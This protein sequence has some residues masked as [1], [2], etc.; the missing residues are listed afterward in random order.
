MIMYRLSLYEKQ[1][2]KTQPTSLQSWSLTSAHAS[3]SSFLPSL[4]NYRRLSHRHLRIWVDINSKF[5]PQVAKAESSR[6]Q[7]SKREE[8]HTS[9]LSPSRFSDLLKTHFPVFQGQ[10]KK[11]LQKGV[12]FDA[13]HTSGHCERAGVCTRPATFGEN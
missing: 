13:H 2:K 4:S 7:K 3:L 10:K 8:G 6:K 9:S 5:E 11:S 12:L 1:L